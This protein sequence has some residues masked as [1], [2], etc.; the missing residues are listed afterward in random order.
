MHDKELA[1]CGV[2]CHGARHGKNA[3]GMLQIIFYAILRKFTL[4]G[5]TGASGSVSVRISALDH[6]TL[7]DS[8]E[9][10]SVI[11]FFVDQ[12][13]K[14]VYGNR[15]GF[16]IKLSLYDISVFHSDCYN[17]ILCHKINLPFCSYLG[18]NNHVG[19][20]GR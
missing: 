7:D 17:R 13:D 18:Y 5:I 14:I 11:K 1:S 15:G 3:F 2:R 19:F 6:E 10:Q 9:N 12:A 16:R 4:D 8:V 20:H